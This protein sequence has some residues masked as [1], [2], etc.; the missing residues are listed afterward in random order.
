[1][2]GRKG[3]LDLKVPA[4]FG[5]AGIIGAYGGARL[6]H[7]VSNSTL[8]LLFAALMLVV[9]VAMLLRKDRQATSDTRTQQGNLALTLLVGLGVGVLT[10]FLGVGGGFLG[11]SGASGLRR[12]ADAPSR[13]YLVVGDSH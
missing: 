2:H 8:L 4:T 9:A 5:S 1:M 3:K 11:R 6:T 7:L 13:R 10:G 12:A